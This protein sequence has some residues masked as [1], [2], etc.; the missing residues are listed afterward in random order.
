MS[1]RGLGRG[2]DELIPTGTQDAHS[3]PVGLLEIPLDQIVPNPHQPRMQIQ[4]QDLAELAASIET[5]GIIQPL[6]VTRS[7]EGRYQLIAGERRWRAA[8]LA[9][10]T[11]VPIIVKDVAS[12]QML[13]LALVENVQRADLN[14]LEEAQAY[15]QL[16]E[17]FGLS[18]EEVARR[19]GK[20]RPAVANTIRLL[21]ASEAIQEAVLDGLLTEGHA[22]ALLGLPTVDE[23][24]EALDIV[25]KGELTVRQTES[26]VRRML[27]GANDKQDVNVARH[28]ET[29]EIRALEERFQASLGTRVQ[30]RPKNKGGRVV[31]YYYSDEEFNALYTR[32]TGEEL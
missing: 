23:Q 32:L 27:A 25:L 28:S 4:A 16:V 14:P 24:D 12:Q 22:R 3:V 13:E 5:H 2:L 30:L 20:S 7:A 6:V 19:V 26:L 31:I 9:G 21:Q 18:Q 15:K 8:R 1:R 29:A 17:E 11:H 10:L